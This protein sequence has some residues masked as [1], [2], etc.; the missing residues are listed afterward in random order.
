M[1]KSL[2][3]I[4]VTYIVAIAFL[5][6]SFEIPGSEE[7]STLT[8]PRQWPMVL[9]FFILILNSIFLFNTLRNKNEMNDEEPE[10][11]TDG[12]EEVLTDEQKEFTKNA[13]QKTEDTKAG[14]KSYRHY[15]LIGLMLVYLVLLTFTNFLIATIIFFP[16]CSIL[17]GERNKITIAV[18]SVLATFLV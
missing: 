6:L 2:V 3:F 7:V 18:S 8:G 1:K 17:M 5:I 16:L 4:F 11:L 10:E 9:I 13:V 15:I 12:L 14:W